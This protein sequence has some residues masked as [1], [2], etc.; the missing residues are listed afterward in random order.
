MKK[1]GLLLIMLLTVTSTFADN[2][3]IKRANCWSL[4]SYK[5]CAYAKVSCMNLVSRGGYV[6]LLGRYHP[7]ET[8]SATALCD[9]SDKGCGMPQREYC[10]EYRQLYD[11]GFWQWYGANAGYEFTSAYPNGR[12]WA[13]WSNSYRLRPG[14]IR[15]VVLDSAIFAEMDK[16]GNTYCNMSSDLVVD[17]EN[18]TLAISNFTGQ[19]SILPESNFY[20][21][22]K[23]ILIKEKKQPT[24]EQVNRVEELGN[25][26]I[27]ENVIASGELTV[28]R[29][30]V[31][32]TGLLHDVLKENHATNLNDTSFG[33]NLSNVSSTVRFDVDLAADETISIVT[34]SDGGLDFS[35]AEVNTGSVASR[36]KIFENSSVEVY[37]N[38]AATS[39]NVAL[40]IKENT[41][42]SV[43]MF[44]IK[45][46]KIANVFNGSVNAGKKILQDIDISELASGLYFIKVV[47]GKKISVHKFTVK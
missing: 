45:G 39:I 6:D 30:G 34:Y 42:V 23:V 1:N 37:P 19:I 11:F 14:V 33:V 31:V 9:R 38:P 22:Y 25:Q 44:N 43:D 27:F 28:T 8:W 5:Y 21:T 16:V 40:S 35:P 26:L 13:H 15:E 3:G 46:E 47:E 20:S 32:A 18:K 12:Q 10:E 2:W 24:E 36:A 7:T 29:N 17:E 41:N 4:F